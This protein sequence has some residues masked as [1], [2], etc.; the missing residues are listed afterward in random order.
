M[1]QLE[2]QPEVEGCLVFEAWYSRRQVCLGPSDQQVEVGRSEGWEGWSRGEVEE[3]HQASQAMVKTAF[4]LREWG[5]GTGGFL[6]RGEPRCDVGVPVAAAVAVLRDQ[7]APGRKQG[8][9]GER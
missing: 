9:A 5:G 1:F 7:W 3:A 4:A 2:G 8:D 6:S